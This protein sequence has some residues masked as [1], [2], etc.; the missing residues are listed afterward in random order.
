[1]GC[2]RGWSAAAAGGQAQPV[3]SESFPFFPPRQGRRKL[4]P[5]HAHGIGFFDARYVFD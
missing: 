5:W 3:E 4:A 1:M 2:S